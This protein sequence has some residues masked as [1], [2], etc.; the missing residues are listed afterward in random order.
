MQRGGHSNSGR[1]CQQRSGCNAKSVAVASWFV[2][3][4]FDC[5][6]AISLP[7]FWELGASL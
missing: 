3:L 5:M 4:D 1:P 6:H 7:R 2:G